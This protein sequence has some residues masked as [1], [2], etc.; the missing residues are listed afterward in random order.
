MVAPVVVVAD[1]GHDGR[2]EVV[3]PELY[4]SQRQGYAGWWVEPDG[5][6]SHEGS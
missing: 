4:C 6:E 3:A 1:E 2:L 5:W